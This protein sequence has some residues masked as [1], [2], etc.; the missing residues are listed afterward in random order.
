ML[1]VGNPATVSGLSP[2][3]QKYS[4]NNAGE[5]ATHSY[6]NLFWVGLQ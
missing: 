3:I 5:Q 4:M 6:I 2:E 1:W